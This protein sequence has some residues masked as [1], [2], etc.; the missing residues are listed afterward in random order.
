[1]ERAR[2]VREQK[3][4][5]IHRESRLRQGV[6]L[7]RQHLGDGEPRPID[8]SDLEREILVGMAGDH[9]F[10]SFVD[11][12]GVFHVVG[13]VARVLEGEHLGC[14]VLGVVGD[15][16]LGGGEEEEGEKAE[17][18]RKIHLRLRYYKW[19]Y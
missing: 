18:G 14:G 4:R 5:Q 17:E 7:E 1:M 13:V 16:I 9:H 19:G 8:I 3:Q 15:P 11:G 10:Q 12:A 2:R 6:S